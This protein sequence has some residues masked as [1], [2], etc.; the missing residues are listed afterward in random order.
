MTDD[1]PSRFLVASTAVCVATCAV[2]AVLPFVVDSS[3]AFTGSVSTS[4]VLGLV[5]AA[6]NLQ[7]L[8]ARGAPSLP[9]AVLTTIFGGWFMLAP[10]LY[11]DV[12]FLPTAGTQLGGT[13]I[14]TFG[15][16]VTVAGVSDE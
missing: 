9:P 1:S 6:R 3:R 15:L 14:A 11:P 8:R 5:F 10:L 13:V 12:G 16:Y 4:G 7:L 2:V